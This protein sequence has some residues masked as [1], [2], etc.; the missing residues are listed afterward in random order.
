MGND[1][2]LYCLA[3]PNVLEETDYAGDCPEDG[4][5]G[6]PRTEHC[7]FTCRNY[8]VV[9]GESLPL[10]L[11]ADKYNPTPNCLFGKRED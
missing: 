6:T 1:G 3:D 7:D 11:K 8:Q 9:E 10:C 2:L 5:N 4:R